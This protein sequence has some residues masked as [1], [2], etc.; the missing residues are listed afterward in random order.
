M[1]I[2][3]ISN[4]ATRQLFYQVS[5]ICYGYK[6]NTEDHK[7]CKILY[8]FTTTINNEAI[9]LFLDARAWVYIDIKGQREAISFTCCVLIFNCT[10]NKNLFY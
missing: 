5:V 7:A 6:I 2:I 9:V 4:K 8:D 1:D 10:K 3:S